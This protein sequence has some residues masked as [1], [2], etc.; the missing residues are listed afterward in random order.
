MRARFF[1][2]SRIRDAY[3]F[4]V[5]LNTSGVSAYDCAAYHYDKVST[6]DLVWSS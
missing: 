3:P 1:L 4:V 6:V 5:I 2:D